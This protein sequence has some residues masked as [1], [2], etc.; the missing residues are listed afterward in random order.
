M[1][2]SLLTALI[3]GVAVAAVVSALHAS[4]LILGFETAAGTV[5][6]DYTSAT[7][8]VSEK[9]QYVLILLLALGVAWLS[10]SSVPRSRI[11]LLVAFLLIE[12]LGLS[13]ICSLYRIFFQP[14]PSVFA[15]AFALIVAEGWIAFLRRDR[16]HLARSLFASRLSSKEFRCVREGT[17]SFDAQPKAYEVSVVACDVANKYGLADDDSGPAAFADA[18]EKF[19]HD[20]ADRL[21]ERG[22]YLQA[23]DGEGVVAIFGFPGGNTERAE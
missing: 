12:L 4:R 5:V 18:M 16:T 9:L 13:W 19:I 11:R 6:S 8:V 23:A 3:I 15:A 20:A 10:L 2:R 22:A 14:L 7:R 17:T 21:L 1:K